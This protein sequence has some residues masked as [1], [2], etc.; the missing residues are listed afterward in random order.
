VRGGIESRGLVE[1][2]VSSSTDVMVA[3]DEGSNGGRVCEDD[4]SSNGVEV[5]ELSVEAGRRTRFALRKVKKARK[6]KQRFGC[7]FYIRN[8]EGDEIALGISFVIPRD[9]FLVYS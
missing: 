7:S 3:R 4:G 5:L 6:G 1:T 9:D 8:F 2:G